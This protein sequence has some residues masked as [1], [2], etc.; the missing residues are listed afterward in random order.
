MDTVP[1]QVSVDEENKLQESALHYSIQTLRAMAE[2]RHISKES[3][4]P[5]Y[6]NMDTLKDALEK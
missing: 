2:A 5:G 1:I 4:V 6:T 3:D